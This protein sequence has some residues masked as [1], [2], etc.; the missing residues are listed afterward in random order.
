VVE[1]P[2][3]SDLALLM[4]ALPPRL[5]TRMMDVQAPRLGTLDESP[6]DQVDE[7][8]SGGT[9]AKLGLVVKRFMPGS[10]GT[11]RET[12]LIEG[13]RAEVS[14]LAKVHGQLKRKARVIFALKPALL[15][16]GGQRV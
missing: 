3:H 11:R 14:C 2:M 13:P 7:G 10:L 8:R 5:G 6:G 15:R 1:L 12:V 4:A 9:L 16:Q